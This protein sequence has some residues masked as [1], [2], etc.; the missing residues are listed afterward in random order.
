MSTT[1]VGQIFSPSS[2]YS[3]INFRFYS[4]YRSYMHHITISM[5]CNAILRE[6]QI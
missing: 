4:L 6:K 5:K 1:K 2:S 3:L